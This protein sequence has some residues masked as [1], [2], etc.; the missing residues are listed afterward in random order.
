[1]KLIGQTLK[2]ATYQ[3]TSGSASWA[4]KYSPDDREMICRLLTYGHSMKTVRD[5]EKMH[6]GELHLKVC[7]GLMVTREGHL[8]IRGFLRGQVG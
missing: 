3:I 2:N 6:P 7:S 1:M 8:G 4:K 5:L